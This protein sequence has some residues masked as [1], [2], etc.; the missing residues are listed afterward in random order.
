[1]T[2]Y[3]GI[4]R[5]QSEVRVIGAGGHAKVVVATL[6]AAGFDVVGLYDEASSKWGTTVL[7]RP[8]IGPQAAM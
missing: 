2:P 6:V 3:S 8:V 7:G 5:K 4:V 1:M